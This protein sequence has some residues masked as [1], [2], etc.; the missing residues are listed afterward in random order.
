MKAKIFD[1]GLY[2]EAIRQSRAIG[3]ICAVINGLISIGFT[4]IMILDKTLFSS[5]SYSLSIEKEICGFFN[6]FPSGA[7]VYILFVPL[8]VLSVF[9][10]LNKRRDSDFYHS[11]PQTRTCLYVSYMSAVATWIFGTATAVTMINSAIYAIFGKYY[12]LNITD[13]VLGL[14]GVFAASA[15]VM[16]AVALAMSL[17]GTLF[18]NIVVSLLII[19]VPRLVMYIFIEGLIIHLPYMQEISSFTIM[20]TGYNI[21]TDSVISFVGS[22][23]S[24]QS[25]DYVTVQSVIYTFIIAALYFV[26]GAFCFNKRR[27]EM[28]GNSAPN[29]SVQSIY[30]IALSLPLSMVASCICIFPALKIVINL[31]EQSE[32]MSD[33]QVE[34]IMSE[35]YSMIGITVVIWIVVVLL[36]LVYEL[37]ATKSW[38]NVLKSFPGLLIVAVINVVIVGSMLGVFYTQNSS[39]PK[40]DEIKYITVSP[41]EE[42]YSYF[43]DFDS[44][45]PS[46]FTYKAETIKL[47]NDALNKM[48][49]KCIADEAKYASKS[50]SSYPEL[51]AEDPQYYYGENAA[52]NSVVVEQTIT[53]GVVTEETEY[54]S[55]KNQTNGGMFEVCVRTGLITK[56]YVIYIE[57]E[58]YELLTKAFSESDEYK[59]IYENFPDPDKYSTIVSLSYRNLPDDSCRSIYEKATEDLKGM[60]FNERYE[61]LTSENYDEYTV[62]TVIVKCIEKGNVYDIEIP[63]GR[64][65]EKAYSRVWIE[66]NENTQE[67]KAE[68]IDVLKSGPNLFGS[69]SGSLSIDVHSESEEHFYYSYCSFEEELL[70]DKYESTEELFEKIIECSEQPADGN[71]TWCEIEYYTYNDEDMFG[72]Q[73]KTL[74]AYFK[75]PDGFAESEEFDNMSNEFYK[76]DAEY[77]GYD[78][79]KYAYGSD[80]ASINNADADEN[81]E[82]AA[83]TAA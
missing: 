6:V 12:V 24:G 60:S 33:G 19:F 55:L 31:R 56:K 45:V 34:N 37:A 48:I 5:E 10:F 50:I 67:D 75:L 49:T 18:N 8:M 81:K 15:F 63:V 13:I 51:Y 77:Y 54:D 71:G 80:D 82:N 7:I 43:M 70:R 3:I 4:L 38:K 47:D 9:K 44:D 72:V 41:Y 36:Y 27:S 40:A 78:Y 62:D 28:A 35:V 20:N 29:K 65:L 73:D 32:Y 61:L 11:I 25:I 79:D 42:N 66:L 14:L 57:G 52:M 69:E 1:F 74:T 58:N 64:K 76:A 22:I 26:L 17:T 2:K 30:R 46:Y 53:D 23:F 59:E 21:V 16:C 68:I 39:V 83:D